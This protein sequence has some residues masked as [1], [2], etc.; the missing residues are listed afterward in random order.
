MKSVQI[1]NISLIIDETSFSGDKS[2]AE[3]RSALVRSVAGAAAT[4]LNEFPQTF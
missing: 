3:V 2:N 4:T 1:L